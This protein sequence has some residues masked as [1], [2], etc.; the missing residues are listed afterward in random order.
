VAFVV[1]AAAALLAVWALDPE[2]VRAAVR[3]PVVLVLAALAALT[4][5]SA[6]WTIGAPADAVRWGA[7]VAGYAAIAVAGYAAARRN[8]PEGVAAL[9]AAL[10]LAAGLVGI[11]A[12]A[13]QAQPLAE[14]IGGAWRPGGPFEYPPALAALQLAA[15]PVALRWMFG[16]RASVAAGAAV[17]AVAAAVIALV[18]S[19]AM[20]ALG[21]L[22]LLAVAAWPART[23]GVGRPA[24]LAAICL[25]L[26]AGAGAD[27]VAGSYADPYVAT[28]DLPR[29]FGLVALL[30]GA[31]ALWTIL[32]LCFD[33]RGELRRGAGRRAAAL[34]L[35]P[36]AAAATAA[37]LTPDAGDAVEP[38]SGLTHG[39]T[40]IWGD[41]VETA[42]EGGFGGS[43]ALTFLD[44]SRAYQD[45]S[46][47]RF[48]HDLVLEQWVELGYPG[49]A[50]SLAL[51][52][53]VVGL[54]VRR[55]AADAGWLLGTGAA[56]YLVAILIDWPW[57][58]PASAA[59]F[60]FLLGALAAP[61]GPPGR[62]R[63]WRPT[64]A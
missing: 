31:I 6:A 51:V 32:R 26:G 10:A 41:A 38:D 64:G 20:L 42:L 35:L 37:A 40:E 54:I 43:G 12:A 15:L 53:V 8:G 33:E 48:A 52:G 1:L 60:T 16:R 30:A 57:H 29:V 9:V 5:A 11:F 62:R 7:V 17:T 59:I 18:S 46:P 14:R 45:P 56:A 34:A 28:A 47:V 4:A 22:L 44:A 61:P 13:A 63:S 39:R 27:A 25:A 50:L 19:R 58:V 3:E 36:L 55:T 21:A 49:L 24:A 2:S 23:L